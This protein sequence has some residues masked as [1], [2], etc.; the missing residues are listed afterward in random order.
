ME[1]RVGGGLKFIQ[2]IMITKRRSRLSLMFVNMQYQN[3][4]VAGGG[5][6]LTIYDIVTQ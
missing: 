6:D 2:I 5:D 1:P 3:P 4:G